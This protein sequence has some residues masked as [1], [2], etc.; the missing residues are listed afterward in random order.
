MDDELHFS[1]LIHFFVIRY[2]RAWLWHMVVGFLFSDGSGNTI[3]W[4]VLPIL[5][6]NWDVIATYNWGSAALAWLYRVLCP[7]KMHLHTSLT[8]YRFTHALP[9]STCLVT[10]SPHGTSIH[11][12]VV[13]SEQ[14]LPSLWCRPCMEG[15]VGCVLTL[16]QVAT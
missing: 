16:T 8:L 1:I 5:C 15:D 10:L 12:V 7:P 3:S 6:F 11:S 2:A 13:V 9:S 4:L 14:S